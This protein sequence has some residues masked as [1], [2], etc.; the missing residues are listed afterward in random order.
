MVNNAIFLTLIYKILSKV[1]KESL[2]KIGQKI[3]VRLDEKTM[4]KIKICAPIA[5]HSSI[6]ALATI[7]IKVF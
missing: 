7:K 6:S 2:L 4:D 1:L 5:E 3:N